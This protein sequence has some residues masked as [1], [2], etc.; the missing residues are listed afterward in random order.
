MDLGNTSVLTD[1]QLM[2]G[3]DDTPYQQFVLVF[4]PESDA[5]NVAG[6]LDSIDGGADFD[7]G[8]AA[9]GPGASPFALGSTEKSVD[10]NRFHRSLA[11]ACEPLSRETAQ[12]RAI[13]LTGKLE[14][15]TDCMRAKGRRGSVPRG[16]GAR[17]PKP[18]GRVH[19]DLCGPLVPSLGGNLY[20]FVAVDSASRL[21][22]DVGRYDLG[23][24][25]CFRVDNGTE[26][27]RGDFRRFCDDNGIGIESTPPGVPQ[28]NGV[29]ESA[30]W[31]VMKAGMAARRSAGRV[32]NVDF[33]FIPGLDERSDRLWMESAKWAADAL[34]Q[35]ATKANPGRRSP[36]EMFTGEQGP[37]RL[38]DLCY[39]LNGG[40]N[41]PSG[42]VKVLKASTGRVVYINN[43]SRVTSAPAGEE[44]RWYHGCAD[45]PPVRAAGRPDQLWPSTDAFDRRTAAASAH[46]VARSCSR[47]RFAPCR[48]RNAAASDHAAARSHAFTAALCRFV[49]TVGD[50]RSR[51]AAAVAGSRDAPGYGSRHAAASPGT[52][53][54]SML[55]KNTLVSMLEAR[56]AVDEERRELRGAE[57]GEPG[58]AGGG[59]QAGALAAV[60][61]GA[62]GAGFPLAFATLLANRE[63]IDA[64]LRDQRPPEQGPD[65]QHCQASDLRREYIDFG[66]LYA[67]TVSVSCVR[68]L[69]AL[70][71]EL[72]LDLC[73]FDIKQAFVRSELEGDEYMRLPQGCGAL[74]RIIEKPESVDY[75][76][77]QASR[78]WHAMLKRL[79]RMD[80][81]AVEYGVVGGSLMWLATQTR[82]DIARAVAGYCAC[83]KLVHW[84][85]A[86]DILGF[87]RRT[88][89]FGISFQKGAINGFSLQGY[90]DANFVSKAADRRSVSGG[91]VTCGGGAVSWFSRTQ[92]CVT[93]STTEAE[94][95]AL[96]DVVKEILF[97]RQIWRFMLPQVGMP[98]IPVFEGN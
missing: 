55:D 47:C 36:H 46:A 85:A 39:Y 48:C 90:A 61:P 78:Q 45:A 53:L 4:I 66:E 49:V 86:M 65:L 25:E 31:R 94:Y 9:L 68:M 83:P 11:H 2:D 50:P 81:L 54:I 29:V 69:A 21:L 27:T 20:L 23:R 24:I 14:P 75:G 51:P 89:H 41:H 95:V 40:D 76:L 80:E 33:V 97:L 71:C 43:V 98:C 42:T 72:N 12:Q 59:E 38:D 77:R 63:D 8:A 84:N 70:E 58:R 57:S 26:W 19:L 28:Y 44:F 1:E 93:L 13:V 79:S 18:L 15:S 52:G 96:G 6:V 34:N 17:A 64:T 92:K 60:D 82:P 32:F 30:I 37:F 73:H 16:P 74:S 87:A 62:G 56:S 3:Y 91:I 7:L 35:S 22:A 88:S 5:A 10:I 67:P